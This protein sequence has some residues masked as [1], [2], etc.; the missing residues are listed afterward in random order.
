MSVRLM[1]AVWR[2]DLPA[3]DKL[4]LLALADA[5]NDEGVT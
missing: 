4:V 1:A 2:L 5:A 3:T